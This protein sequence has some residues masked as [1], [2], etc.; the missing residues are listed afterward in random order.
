MLAP[1]LRYMIR[2]GAERYWFPRLFIPL[3]NS[4]EE[5]YALLML[6]VEFQYLNEWGKVVG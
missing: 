4:F 6:I 1:A 3:N 5:V 2:Q